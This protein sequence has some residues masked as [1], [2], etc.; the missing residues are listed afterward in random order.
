MNLLLLCLILSNFSSLARVSNTGYEESM[1][2]LF[3]FSLF[4]LHQ[5]VGRTKIRR[6][7]IRLKENRKVSSFGVKCLMKLLF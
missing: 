4:D 5:Y 7:E 6:N 3:G 2:L 1:N